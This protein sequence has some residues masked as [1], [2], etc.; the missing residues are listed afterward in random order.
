[1]SIIKN[2]NSI[3]VLSDIHCKYRDV[4]IQRLVY[5]LNRVVRPK[6]IIIVEDENSISDSCFTILNSLDSPF[7]IV[8]DINST[9]FFNLMD[10]KIPSFNKVPFP[11]IVIDKEREIEVEEFHLAMD[12]NLNLTDN[13]IHTQLAY[14][15]D[16]M[17]IETA[18]ELG[19]LFGLR[20][21]TITEHS[22]H[23]YFNINEYGRKECYTYGLD[24]ANE[25]NYRMETYLDY[26]KKYSSNFVRFGLELDFGFD[27]KPMVLQEDLKQFD[28][29]L[30]TMHMIP[31]VTPHEFMLQLERL[32][33]YGIDVIA[34]PFRIFK[35]NGKDIPM[36]I[37]TPAVE[38]L[39]KYNTAA[40][41]NFHTNEPPVEF[42]RECLRLGVRFSFGSDSHNL[43]EIGDFS[44][45]LDLLKEAGFSGNL[46]DILWEMD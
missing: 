5:R 7:Y 1:M 4:I 19:H 10:K 34:H 12:K 17:D 29:I 20:A 45:N 14:C 25:S 15:S 23:L 42:V 40:E 11:Y 39:K 6:L 2:S 44:Y 33:S 18:I 8:K 32:L 43:A 26:K 31:D 9:P 46:K 16:N 24:R 13:H 30:G 36:E 37:I 3:V 38:L 27:G 22:D 21:M 28:F 35:L 41:I